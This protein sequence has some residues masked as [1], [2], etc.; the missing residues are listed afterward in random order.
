M[1]RRATDGQSTELVPAALPD[2]DT[3]S[4]PMIPEDVRADLLRAQ[5]ESI[6]TPPKLPQIKVLPQAVCLFEFDDTNETQRTFEAVILGSHSSNVLWDKPFGESEAEEGPACGAR[7]AKTGVPREGFLHA[8]LQRL[9]QPTDR[10]ACA[11]CPYNRFESA[12][13]IGKRG[14]GKA[15]TNQRRIYL[16]LPGKALPYLL[17]AS[18]TSITGYDEYLTTLLNGGTPAQAVVT[19]FTQVRK[20][21]ENN[22]KWS[23]L[24]F[25]RVR[26]LDAEEFA[27][28]MDQRT[29]FIRTIDPRQWTAADGNV[30]F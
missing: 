6:E 23:Q 17:I 1:P 15:C 21:G 28:V 27:S 12:A 19:E 8:A 22:L 18:P 20:E 24:T 30:P 29:R 2:S 5:A 7:D 11:S 9:P 10:I 25:R 4:V 13:L 16:S 14:K 3:A 26:T